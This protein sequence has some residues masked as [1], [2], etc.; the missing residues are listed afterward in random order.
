MATGEMAI[1]FETRNYRK[2]PEVLG[3]DGWFTAR[4]ATCGE[5]DEAI[6]KRP[7]LVPRAPISKW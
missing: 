6:K 3:C 7:R 4:V 1:S 2:L 5:L